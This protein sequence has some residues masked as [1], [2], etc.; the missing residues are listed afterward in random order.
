MGINFEE[1][2]E[3]FPTKR[4][5]KM[6]VIGLLILIVGGFSIR[7]IGDY[8]IS[9]GNPNK[10]FR[11]HPSYFFPAPD[12]FVRLCRSCGLRRHLALFQQ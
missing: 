9:V 3:N 11:F 4:I 12:I 8:I 6:L 10:P 2:K 5:V 1:L 7:T